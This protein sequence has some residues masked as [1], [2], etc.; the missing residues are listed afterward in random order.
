MH[1]VEVSGAV[2]NTHTHVYIYI[3]VFRRQ[4]VNGSTIRYVLLSFFLE[5]NRPGF[6]DDHSM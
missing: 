5:E 2:R 6:E 1:R 3:Y 4:S